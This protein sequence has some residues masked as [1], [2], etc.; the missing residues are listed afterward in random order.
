MS[1]VGTGE[2]TRPAA[3]T[4][5]AASAVAAL[6]H[7]GFVAP[8]SY[9]RPTA[10]SGPLPRRQPQPLSVVDREQAEALVRIS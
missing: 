7:S 6:G 3:T 2:S 9:L 4:A 10:L 5:A 1:E 8:S